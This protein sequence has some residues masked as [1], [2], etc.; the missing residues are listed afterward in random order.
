[1]I[2]KISFKPV[3]LGSIAILTVL[4]VACGGAAAPAAAPQIQ[5]A[6]STPPPGIYAN[7]SP[8]RHCSSIRSDLN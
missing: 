4:L 7:S 8:D 3:V 5:K 1:M 6:T 2:N